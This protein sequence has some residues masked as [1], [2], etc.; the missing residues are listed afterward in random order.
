MT[1]NGEEKK[2]PTVVITG[3]GP[4]YH[5]YDELLRHYDVAVMDPQMANNLSAERGSAGV[6]CP[7]NGAQQMLFE[8]A[9]NEA[10]L[11]VVQV[12]RSMKDAFSLDGRL[13]TPQALEDVSGWLPGL[14][15]SFFTDVLVNIRALDAWM[16]TGVELA[17]VVLHEDVTPR[18]KAL[19]MWGK[20]QGVPVFHVPHNN[21][22]LTARP[23]IHDE[24]DADWILA[25]S[26]YMRSWYAERGFSKE[27][28]K[29]VGFPVWDKWADGRMS[30]AVTRERSRAVLHLEPD[31]PVVTFCT[32]WPQR[33]NF[34]DDHSMLEAASHLILQ[35][36]KQE[37]WQVVWKM[38]PGDRPE[39]EGGYAQLAAGYRVPAVVTRD[40]LAFSLAA[41]DVAVSVGPSNVLV[42][43]GIFGTPPALFDLR[44]YGFPGEPPYV[45][46]PELSNIVSTLGRFMEG[47]D[48]DWQAKK[49]KFVR[50]FAFKVDGKAAKRTVRQIKRIIEG[51]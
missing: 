11:S 34:V 35:A 4:T 37:G 30:T 43:A 29:I 5:L 26:A 45:V 24:S 47:P 12:A 7:L 41:A 46:E 25:A 28:I 20:E 31:R 16:E 51:V 3:V 44:G 22:Y 2:R 6:T 33:T 13:P 21:S 23:D 39:A 19:G 27:R 49:R 50:R 48:L 15:A 36:A 18:Y 9:R 32:G 40:H 8:R 42:E 17:A 38:H 1:E 10:A 14:A